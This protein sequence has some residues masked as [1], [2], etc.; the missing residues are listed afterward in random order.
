MDGF[1]EL[2]LPETPEPWGEPDLSL[3]YQETISAPAFPDNVLPAAWARWTEAAAE[4]AGAPQ[5]FVAVA[6]LAATGSLIGNARWASPW[7]DWR[8]PPVINVALIGRPSSGKSPAIDQVANLLAGIEAEANADYGDR[9]REAKRDAAEAAERMKA[10][11]AQVKEAVKLGNAAPLPPF[12]TIP[13]QA[14]PRRRLYST[15]PTTEAAARLSATNPRGLLLLRDEL[16][17]WI[18]SMDRYSGGAGGDRQFWLQAYGGRYWTPDRVKDGDEPL[19]VHHLLWAV[20]GGIQPDRVASL[21]MGGDDDGLSA[22]F[23]YCWPEPLPPRRP[24]SVPDTDAAIARFRRLRALVW[25]ND[26]EPQIVP[27]S[28]A[29]A[30]V[31]QEWREQIA[32]LEQSE[33]G[34]FLSWIGKLPGMAI[35]LALILEYLAWSGS[36]DGTPE[37]EEIS[38]RAIV[39]AVVFLDGFAIPMARRTFGAAA[40]P[41]AERD[42]RR[43]ARWLI[44]QT[45]IPETVNARD[46]RRLREGPQIGDAERMEAALRELEGARWCRATP[47]RAGGTSGRTRKDWTINPAIERA[48]S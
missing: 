3:I 45:P 12:E 26:P 40:L 35:R 11:E 14:P 4:G 7:N 17:G 42:A 28:E 44:H 46:L 5:P 36:P 10:W 32:R 25:G 1:S 22:R 48:R 31:V 47:T 19:V 18:A 43:L 30:D 24:S 23:L 8:E 33:A 21:M 20:L 13:T 37:P 41:Q 16:A 29:A 27:F 39:A 2:K 15:S 34:L 38:E 9:K 6:L